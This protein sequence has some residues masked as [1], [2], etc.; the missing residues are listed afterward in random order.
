MYQ[1]QACWASCVVLYPATCLL[2]PAA[3]VPRPA[4]GLPD[5]AAGLQNDTEFSCRCAVPSCRGGV[6]SCGG[7]IPWYGCAIPA[8]DVPSLAAGVLYSQT[9]PC[10]CGGRSP[11]PGGLSW[12]AY[13]ASWGGSDQSRRWRTRLKAV[14]TTTRRVQDARVCPRLKR[15]QEGSPCCST[16]GVG[17]QQG[18]QGCP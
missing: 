2:L 6:S 3:V 18:P 16:S 17:L 4:A 15:C 12:S 9:C 14:G 11:K 10:A 13:V 7:A 8:A 1:L 5:Q